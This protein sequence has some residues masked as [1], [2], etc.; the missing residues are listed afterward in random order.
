MQAAANNSSFK[1]PS[2]HRLA[3]ILSALDWSPNSSNE[4]QNDFGAMKSGLEAEEKYVTESMSTLSGE[5]SDMEDEPIEQCSQRWIRE[6][7]PTLDEENE[8]LRSAREL[9]EVEEELRDEHFACLQVSCLSYS[10]ALRTWQKRLTLLLN[11]LSRLNQ[12]MAQM[13]QEEF[14]MIQDIEGSGEVSD[15]T[16]DNYAIKLAEYLDRKELLIRSVQA[17]FEMVKKHRALNEAIAREME[18]SVQTTTRK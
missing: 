1:G 10:G 2:Q 7:E 3:R 6:S 17:R 16:M 13:L 4:D 15:D 14:I 5:L 8:A 18:T 9:F 12:D 11:M